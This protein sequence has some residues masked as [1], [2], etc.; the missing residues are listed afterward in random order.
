ML[1]IM[2]GIDKN[3]ISDIKED[4]LKNT[5]IRDIIYVN[6]CSE[7]YIVKDKNY[8]Y[9]LDSKYE[10][11]LKKEIKLLYENKNNYEMVY[12]DNTIVYFGDDIVKNRL[13]FKYYDIYTYEII[14]EVIVG[15]N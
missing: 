9:L 12:R 10:E 2:V 6:K 14:D 1:C 4:I 8:L 11:V 13:V 5:K 15:D 7:Y 3:S